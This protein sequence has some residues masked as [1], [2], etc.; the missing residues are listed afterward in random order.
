MK[1]CPQEM[2]NGITTRSPGPMCSTSEPDLL[3]DAHRLVPEDVA[4]VMNGPSTS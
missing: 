2:L 4:L 1:Q 3:D